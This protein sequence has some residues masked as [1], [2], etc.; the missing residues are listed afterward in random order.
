MELIARVEASYGVH[1][2][3]IPPVDVRFE[4]NVRPRPAQGQLITITFAGL[5]D[6]NA[7]SFDLWRDVHAPAGELD[8]RWWRPTV[9]ADLMTAANGELFLAMDR[10]ADEVAAFA[11]D[12]GGAL[13]AAI[14]AELASNH[15]TTMVTQQARRFAQVLR[16]AFDLEMAPLHPIEQLMALEHAVVTWMRQPPSEVALL[17]RDLPRDPKSA[18][19]SAVWLAWWW[20]FAR[21]VTAR[22]LR[23][24]VTAALA[25]ARSE[26]GRDPSARAALDEATRMA[27]V[28]EHAPR[29]QAFAAPVGHEVLRDPEDAHYASYMAVTHAAHAIAGVLREEITDANAHAMELVARAAIDATS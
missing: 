14:R 9:L 6:V 16:I 22:E 10:T 17:A 25:V 24:A 28:A 12:R 20:R 2:V 21:A 4:V 26:C 7:G 15:D 29:A 5:M 8:R 3:R 27:A 18:G 13:L 23:A 19:A 11:N 1:F